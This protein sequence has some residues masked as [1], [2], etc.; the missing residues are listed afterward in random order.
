[1]QVAPPLEQT[2]GPN[3][4]L[5]GISKY[6]VI[7]SGGKDVSVTYTHIQMSK[8]RKKNVLVLVIGRVDFEANKKMRVAK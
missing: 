5:C 6:F 2:K 4:Q 7:S 3:D 1:M 8:A